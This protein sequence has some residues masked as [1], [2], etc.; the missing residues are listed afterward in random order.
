MVQWKVHFK[1][2]D[3]PFEQIPQR[4]LSYP[5]HKNGGTIVQRSGK[6]FHVSLRMRSFTGDQIDFTFFDKVDAFVANLIDKEIR[7]LSEVL[8]NGFSVAAC[9]GYPVRHNQLYV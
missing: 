5:Q 4:A 7:R 1:C 3:V 6:N 9:Y 2:R 8:I